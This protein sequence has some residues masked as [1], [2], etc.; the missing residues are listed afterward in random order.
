LFLS[1]IIGAKFIQQFIRTLN[2]INETLNMKN[3][4]KYEKILQYHTQLDLCQN[5]TQLTD[6]LREKFLNTRTVVD[7]MTS[8]V[9]VKDPL[10][11]QTEAEKSAQKVR[12]FG[13]NPPIFKVLWDFL[14]SQHRPR[15]ISQVE[16]LR[17]ISKFDQSSSAADRLSNAM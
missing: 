7:S 6:D 4:G 1:W 10:V 16:S 5:L 8:R 12:I 15:A 14:D 3:V 13:E 9:K 17:R 11:G 2:Q